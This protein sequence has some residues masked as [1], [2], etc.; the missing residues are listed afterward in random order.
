ML[1]KK[2]THLLFH[3]HTLSKKWALL[4][5]D[6][7][8]TLFDF[9]LKANVEPETP[10]RKQNVMTQSKKISPGWISFRHTVKLNGVGDTGVKSLM[11]LDILV[12]R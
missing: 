9:P 10:K 3:Q 11:S 6:E 12:I 4:N 1:F 5:Y 8:M 2:I 7:H